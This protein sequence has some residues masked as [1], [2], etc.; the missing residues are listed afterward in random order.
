MNANNANGGN[1]GDLAHN[2][3]VH[4]PALI[5]GRCGQMP[6]NWTTFGVQTLVEIADGYTRMPNGTYLDNTGVVVPKSCIR[7]KAYR[8][9]TF[10][11]FG[12][13]GRGVCNQLP[14]CVVHPICAA[15]PEVE[16]QYMGF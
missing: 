6:C 3:D 2:S 14:D 9:V 15:Y 4:Q 8:M 10:K 12:T 13:L 1:V 11:K 5:C 16:N 7:K